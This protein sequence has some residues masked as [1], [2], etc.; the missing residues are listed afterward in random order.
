M[1]AILQPG[2]YGDILLCVGLANATKC[3]H[4]VVHRKYR[5]I[6]RHFPQFQVITVNSFDYN[7]CVEACYD[8]GIYDIVDT[9]FGFN[10]THRNSWIDKGC[11]FDELKY[12]LN[13]VGFENKW[14]QFDWTRNPYKE[15]EVIRYYNEENKYVFVHDKPEI[16]GLRDLLFKSGIKVNGTKVIRPVKLQGITIC[17]Y[18]QLLRNADEIHCIDSAFSNF[19][20]LAL[21]EHKK[22][23]LHTNARRHT[24]GG[25]KIATYKNVNVL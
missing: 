22:M 20:E 1:K 13:G 4:W 19:C 16:N 15:M 7:I 24:V 10:K 12:S 25:K 21:C 8:K 3:T 2:K 18:Y 9:H 23:F 14:N 17:D 11:R 5:D 6:M